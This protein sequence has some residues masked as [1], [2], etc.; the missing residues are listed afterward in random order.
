MVLDGQSI[1]AL[2]VHKILG[3]LDNFREEL[4]SCAVLVRSSKPGCEAMLSSTDQR[5]ICTSEIPCP[6]GPTFSIG[7]CWET[8]VCVG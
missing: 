4:E 6:L 8:D 2:K 7:D 3:I 1:L 5:I